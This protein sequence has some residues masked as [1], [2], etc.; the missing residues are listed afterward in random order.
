V[1][2][3]LDRSVDAVGLAGEGD[4]VGGVGLCL[5][6]VYLVDVGGV[7][8]A[9]D[10]DGRDVLNILKSVFC[11]PIAKSIF[12]H[13]RYLD[14]EVRVKQCLELEWHIALVGNHQRRLQALAVKRDAVQETK[15]VWPQLAGGI[16]EVL[17]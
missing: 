16:V 12:V 17:G 10:L 15:L 7:F 11:I 4:W 2:G 5:C 3:A 9:G 13:V 6:G 14:S 8:E 1:A